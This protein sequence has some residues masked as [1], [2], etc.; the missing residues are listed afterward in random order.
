MIANSM[1][2]RWLL[3]PALLL[4]GGALRAQESDTKPVPPTPATPGDRGSVRLR[5]SA[6]SRPVRAQQGLF[7][8]V[9]LSQWDQELGVSVAHVDE[10]LRAQL[11]LPDKHGLIVTALRANSPATRAGLKRHDILLTAAG[12]PLAMVEDLVQAHRHDGPDKPWSLK[13]L[14]GGKERTVEVGP[15]QAP[16]W[17]VGTTSTFQSPTIDRLELGYHI[18]VN[19]APVDGALRSHME[20]PAGKGLVVLGTEHGGPAEK[21]GLKPHDILLTLG[22]KDLADEPALRAAIQETKGKATPVQLLRG[23][24]PLTVEVTPAKNEVAPP[25]RWEVQTFQAQEDYWVG[26]PTAPVGAALRGHLGLP[27]G[28]GLLVRILPPEGPAAKAGFKANDILL[29]AGDKELT[30]E[31]QLRQAVQEAKDK[32]ITFTLLRAGKEMTLAVTPEKRSGTG[33]VS[34]V[35]SPQNFQLFGPGVLMG[36]P[37]PVLLEPNQQATVRHLLGVVNQVNGDGG[38][39]PV[40][41]KLDDLSARLE[42]LTKAVEDLRATIKA[43][44]ADKK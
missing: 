38:P 40:Q 25:T 24:K 22:E 42:R 29:K 7:R 10:T 31:D 27:D 20:I 11:D 21:A 28:K 9:T 12:R 23:G 3:A 15:I 32:P 34:Y 30:S 2:L 4:A 26:L 39:D 41:K 44:G 18:G 35:V 5:E 33:N 14:R 37:N 43:E 19:V 6:V 8:N 1:T 13:L 36:Q 16:R 17:H